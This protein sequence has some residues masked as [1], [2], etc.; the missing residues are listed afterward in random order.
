MKVKINLTEDWTKIILDRISN[1]QS[2]GFIFES[3]KEWKEQ[4]LY[5]LSGQKQALMDKG[6]DYSQVDIEIGKTDLDHL[7]TD[8]LLHTYFDFESRLIEDKPRIVK[9]PSGFVCPSRLKKGRD[10]LL[11][12]VRNGK[13]LF[14]HLSRQI[15][16]ANF[17]DGMLFDWGVQHFHL[18]LTPDKKRPKL[19]EGTKEVL[20]AIVKD[21]TFYAIAIEDHGHWASKDLLRIVRDNFPEIIK[22]F[23]IEGILALSQTFS[24]KEHIQ[25]RNSGVNTINELDGEFYFSPGG[26]INTARGSMISTQRIIQ[27]HR[28]Y[29]RAEEFIDSEF[30][31]IWDSIP[32]EDGTNPDVINLKMLKEE[33]DRITTICKD[34][35]FSVVLFYNRERNGFQSLSVQSIE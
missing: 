3:F 31:K 15:F 18:G 34:H 27:I 17:M 21:D 12:K 29:V 4:R 14:P 1:L 13:N 20:Y 33:N 2:N 19:I 26:G 24:E 9:I 16:D 10:A 11:E 23:K 7:F 8:H 22:P 32:K 28:W 35:K 30:T 6:E 5:N 25:L